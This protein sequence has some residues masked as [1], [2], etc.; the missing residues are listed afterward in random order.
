MGLNFSNVFYLEHPW[1]IFLI[2]HV[3][4]CIFM[5]YFS[6]IQIFESS[7][8]YFGIRCKGENQTLF[9]LPNILNYLVSPI[10]IYWIIVIFSLH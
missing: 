4:F 6:Y 10:I 7:K 9:P 5:V 1:D 2:H 3:F 8:M